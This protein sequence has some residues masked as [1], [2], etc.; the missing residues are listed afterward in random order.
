MDEVFPFLMPPLIFWPE[1]KQDRPVSK[2]LLT[3][4]ELFKISLAKFRKRQGDM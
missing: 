2:R 4:A 3:V 1:Q